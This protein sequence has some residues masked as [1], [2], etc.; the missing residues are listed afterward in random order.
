MRLLP[1]I[2]LDGRVDSVT[3]VNLSIGRTR[4]L[5]L[6]VR[7]PMTLHPCLVRPAEV[8]TR[9]TSD[10]DAENDCLTIVVPRIPAWKPVTL[11]FADKGATAPCP[12]QTHATCLG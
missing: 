4:D 12:K 5:T 8:A 10:Y 1:H 7:R 6:K 3:I 2:S 9:A 11:C